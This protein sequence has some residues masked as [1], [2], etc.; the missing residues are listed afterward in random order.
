MASASTVPTVGSSIGGGT[1]RVTP[2]GRPGSGEVPRGSA[3]RLPSSALF[4]RSGQRVMVDGGV[5]EVTA[6]PDSATIGA[7]VKVPEPQA[8]LAAA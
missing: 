3:R 5:G 4:R 8:E 1:W 6:D 7:A 2:S